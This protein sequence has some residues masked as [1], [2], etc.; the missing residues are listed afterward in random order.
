M[1]EQVLAAMARELTEI[2]RR[3]ASID[4][5]LKENVRAKLRLKIKSMLKR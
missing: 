2:L 1:Q 3:D 4:G 5:Q